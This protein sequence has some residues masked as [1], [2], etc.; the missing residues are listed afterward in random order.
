[1]TRVS[2][3]GAIKTLGAVAAA[4]PVL[5]LPAEVDVLDPTILSAIAEVVLPSETN[6]KMAVAAF[7]KWINEYT[8]NADTDHGYGNTRVRATGPSPAKNYPAHLAALDTAARGAGAASFATAPVDE[9]RRILEAAIAG[10]KVERLPARPT[11]AHIATDLMGHFFNSSAANDLCYRAYIRRDE[12]RGL[13]G[14][15]MP[16]AP[17]APAAPRAPAPLAPAA[18][19]APLAP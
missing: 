14:S 10:A 1:V 9:R 3:R 16:P 15:E 11:G 13:A 8:E 7:A 19:S 12:C 4:V 5:R 6:H 18:R 17:L 2:R